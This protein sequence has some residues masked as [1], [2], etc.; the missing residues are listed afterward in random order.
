M[1]FEKGKYY[2]G[3]LCYIFNDDS[4]Q[5]ICDLLD[6]EHFEFKGFKMWNHD[7]AYGDGCYYDADNREYA[8]DAGLI[9]I[10]PIEVIEKNY[11]GDGGQ[12][13]EFKTNFE[14]YYTNGVFCIGD[15]MIY[16]K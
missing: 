10:A 7:T 15:I 1:K 8:V 12:I 14:P 3:D 13:I 16:T 5:K 2:V 11:S 4:W 6:N 9:G